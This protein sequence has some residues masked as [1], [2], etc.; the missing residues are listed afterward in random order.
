M[1]GRGAL[2]EDPEVVVVAP[3]GVTPPAEW[4]VP[5]AALDGEAWSGWSSRTLARGGTARRRGGALAASLVSVHPEFAARDGVRRVREHGPRFD[6]PTTDAIGEIARAVR[7]AGGRTWLVGGSVRDWLAGELGPDGGEIRAKDADLEIQNLDIGTLTRILS[8]HFAVDTAGVSFAVLKVTVP[9]TGHQI[10]V[11]LPRRERAI[12]ESRGHQDFEIAYDPGLDFV[13][14]A[15]RRDFTIGAMGFDPLTGELLDPYGGA[16]D[17]A[18]GV[19]RHVSDAFADDPLRV[20]RAARFAAR[21]D[22]RVHPDT[23]QL[24]RSLRPYADA[25]S[26]ERRFGELTLTL[27]QA[28][29][30]GKALHVLDDLAWIDVFE[31]VA[32][33][34]AVAQSPAWHPE[35]DVFNHTAAALDFWGTHLRTGDARD[36]LVV[37][38]AVLAHD[39]GKVSTTRIDEAGVA[40]ARGHEAA[41]GPVVQSFLE[42]HRQPGLAEEVVPLVTHHLAPL[43]LVEQGAGPAAWRRLAHS[44]GRLDRLALV[45]RA[46]VGGRPPLDPAARLVTID[47]FVEVA[48]EIGVEHGGPTPLVGGRDLIALGLRPG[49]QFGLLL[50]QAYQDQLD[51]VF[52]TTEEGRGYL[53]T[54]VERS[55]SAHSSGGTETTHSPSSSG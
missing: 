36:D 52:S 39:F 32:Q 34:R 55:R 9:G 23:A 27:E 47:R 41:G 24:C 30:P 12:G 13:A 8:Q 48:R 26:V 38:L 51:G 16:A 54:L 6:A 22:L 29:R 45:S 14:A 42:F 19:L 2:S 37:S 21:F 3:D 44:V 46:D 1:R 7:D 40:H 15:A 18:A 20:L 5:G 17:L 25:L 43:Q 53:A 11:A 31:P 33:L 10:D 28:S 4:F 49:P 50:R 35:G